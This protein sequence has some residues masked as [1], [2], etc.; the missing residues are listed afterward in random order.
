MDDH[1]VLLSETGAVDTLNFWISFFRMSLPRVVFNISHIESV[2]SDAFQCTIERPAYNW[3][4][5]DKRVVTYQQ[6]MNPHHYA[7]C[8]RAG[9]AIYLKR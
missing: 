5:N 6:N 8:V 4:Q 7:A 1:Q 9:N 3:L 2:Q